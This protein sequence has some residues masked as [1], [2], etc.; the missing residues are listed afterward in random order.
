VGSDNSGG[1]TRIFPALSGNRARALSRYEQYVRELAD[2]VGARPE[3]FVGAIAERIR[4][5][6]IEPA[7]ESM[8]AQ[9]ALTR[10]LPLVGRE[11]ALGALS[12][13]WR[14]C[15]SS[16]RTEVVAI[17]A[18]AGLGKTRLAEEL[19]ARVALDGG[20]TVR[21]RGVESDVLSPW[22]GLLGL[23]RAGLLE[24]PGVA[25]APPQAHAAFAEHIAEWGDRFPGSAGVEPAPLPRAFSDLVRSAA[26]E[27]PVLIVADD[28]H[29]LDVES[30]QSLTS[31]PR[32]LPDAPMLLLLTADP[33][34]ESET[35]D[36]LRTRFGRD[37]PGQ[38]IELGPL[39]GAAL[40]QMARAVFPSYVD[41]AVDRLAR[42]IQADSAGI[43]LLAIEIL[44]AISSGLDWQVESGA[45]PAPFHTLTQTTPGDLPDTVVS[46]VRYGFRRLSEPAQRALAAA[47]ALGGRQDG[48]RIGRAAGLPAARLH[49][50]L[51]EL[52]WQRWL[53]ADAQGYSFVARIVERIVDRDM[54]TPGQRR[55][56]RDA[57]QE[58]ID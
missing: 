13:A 50:A 32:D 15:S 40:R 12:E 30:L 37:H 24:A 21:V 19:M 29:Y 46:A 23:G 57:G 53:V 41:E 58:P 49:A 56:M 33:A 34:I 26:E 3:P 10:R 43:P 39:E 55:R 52:E 28:C 20:G 2:L 7:P 1:I 17:L 22:S 35:L 31:L 54:V 18:D 16:R 27:H 8:A 4:S 38:T 42:R 11:E 14:R 51:D 9:V 48:A 44:H 36:V 45:W 5:G 6:R 47:A 25:A